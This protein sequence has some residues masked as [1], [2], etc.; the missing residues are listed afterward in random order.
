MYRLRPNPVLADRPHDVP[1]AAQVKASGELH[2]KMDG[3]PNSCP[4]LP[5]DTH[6]LRGE[7]FEDGDGEGQALLALGGHALG[8]GPE[9]KGI[10]RI[11]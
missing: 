2:G 4:T 11:S 7:R 10:R 9:L 3:H 1:L 6:A 8:Q 5:A